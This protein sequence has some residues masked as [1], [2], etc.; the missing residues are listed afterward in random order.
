MTETSN[1][2][3]KKSDQHG[4]INNR[5][6][7]AINNTRSTSFACGGTTTSSEDST[8]GGHDDT[9]DDDVTKCNVG[10]VGTRIMSMR[11]SNRDS[12][13]IMCGTG[14]GDDGM[15]CR[16]GQDLSHNFEKDITKSYM[17]ST[18][19]SAHTDF[20]RNATN[21][22]VSTRS[23]MYDTKRSRT[24]ETS[25]LDE[26]DGFT[27]YTNTTHST[28]TRSTITGIT[29]HPDSYDT[30]TMT[31][32]ITD[33][34][35]TM[36]SNTTASIQQHQHQQQNVMHHVGNN[37]GLENNVH[38]SIKEGQVLEYD[39]IQ[40]SF[41]IE[42]T[43]IDDLPEVPSLENHHQQTEQQQEQMQQQPKQENA[44]AVSRN[45][46]KGF[47]NN[48][49]DDD[50]DNTD[51]HLSVD[52]YGVVEYD[53]NNN[54][55]DDESLCKKQSLTKATATILIDRDESCDGTS[56]SILSSRVS[57]I[58]D[59]LRSLGTN[60]VSSSYN[61]ST[62][63]SDN[64]EEQQQQQQRQQQQKQQ[65]NHL[66]RAH[67]VYNKHNS[68]NNSNGVETLLDEKGWKNEEG[69][70]A[71]GG[72]KKFIK[73]TFL[74]DWFYH[75]FIAVLV[76]ALVVL[77]V[78]FYKFSNFD[79][80]SPSS[81]NP[82]V[83]SGLND[84]G[85]AAVMDQ[86]QQVGTY[87]PQSSNAHHK[88]NED[89]DN[90]FNFP[91]V[92]DAASTIA[93]ASEGSISDTTTVDAI[94]AT[95]PVSSTDALL[96][97][98]LAPTRYWLPW[99]DAEEERVNDSNVLNTRSVNNAIPD[100]VSAADS[101]GTVNND[102]KEG[103]RSVRRS[104]L[105]RRYLIDGRTGIGNKVSI[106]N[107]VNVAFVDYVQEEND[108]LGDG[109]EQEIATTLESGEQPTTTPPPTLSPTLSPTETVTNLPSNEP[110]FSAKEEK[111]EVSAYLS[112]SASN[113]IFHSRCWS[114]SE[115]QC[116][117]CEY[118]KCYDPALDSF[119]DATKH[120]QCTYWKCYNYN[121]C[122][123]KSV[124]SSTKP[125]TLFPTSSPTVSPAPTKTSEP[126]S[127]PTRTPEPSASVQR[128]EDDEVPLQ[129]IESTPIPTS[130][131]TPKPSESPSISPS[132]FPPTAQTNTVLSTTT[133]TTFSP[134]SRPTTSNIPTNTFAPTATISPTISN[135]PTVRRT[136]SPSV[137]WWDEIDELDVTTNIDVD[138]TVMTDVPTTPWW[139]EP[140]DD[141]TD[142]DDTDDDYTY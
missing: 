126:S 72:W 75:G 66:E 74:N 118:H 120:H 20:T 113:Q 51:I 136:D 114:A 96:S 10:G 123:G 45:S 42:A 27:R 17:F 82:F 122:G 54:D 36:A 87:L 67:H 107:L 14:V 76:I 111:N 65:V 31:T 30:M 32:A 99:Y 129:A 25:Y 142:D 108:K 9:D 79:A 92:P 104:K 43:P 98:T 63:G 109:T 89:H 88:D 46:S 81:S 85:A 56:R 134:S 62:K 131:P 133:T 70:V 60:S 59:K 5:L 53:Y 69:S 77:S 35:D 90:I 4:I 38:N 41:S 137:F 130:R 140:F 68:N 95:P 15:N 124:C 39:H 102:E 28:G 13:N 101:N 115:S 16:Q 135:W 40:S 112:T 103:G 19:R 132:S 71:S 29:D 127:S 97:A 58:R 24:N 18:S 138:D 73:R 105:R 44:S 47:G 33:D 50:D 21:T 119:T 64:D 1:W 2:G 128:Q 11:N 23:F 52:S 78:L 100:E 34:E 26:D 49:H 22:T 57:M 121:N 110:S 61:V 80:S 48:G 106:E 55:D 117:K 125:P 86:T 6:I 91:T 7:E 83:I 84:E 8:T 116:L 94:A 3:M 139:A 12:V 93:A 37:F 141:D